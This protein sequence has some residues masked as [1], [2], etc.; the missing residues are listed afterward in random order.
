MTDRSDG[1]TAIT[2]VGSL[3]AHADHA[4]KLLVTEIRAAARKPYTDIPVRVHLQWFG[5][6]GQWVVQEYSWNIGTNFDELSAWRMM[7]WHVDPKIPGTDAQTFASPSA[8]RSITCPP[9]IA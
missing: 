6:L 1:P 2:T 9:D 7:R 3:P 8:T 5:Q 4:T